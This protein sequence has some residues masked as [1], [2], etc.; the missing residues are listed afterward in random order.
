VLPT[1]RL[2]RLAKQAG[3]KKIVL[4]GSYFAHF[5]EAW[6]DLNLKKENAYPRT[7]LL[8]EEVSFMEGEGE[9]DVPNYFQGPTTS[10][11]SSRNQYKLEIQTSV[12]L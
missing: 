12:A 1:Q 10:K 3:V 5:T 9:M 4:F 2:A 7:R 8:Q 11:M 6:H